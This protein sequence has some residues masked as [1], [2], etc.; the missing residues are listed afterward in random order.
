M[1]KIPCE[2]SKKSPHLLPAGFSGVPARS[3]WK[4]KRSRKRILAKRNKYAKL[5]AVY[6]ADSF[7]WRKGSYNTA[8]CGDDRCG[9]RHRADGDRLRRSSRFDAGAAAFVWCGYSVRPIDV[10]LYCA[11]GF[12]CVEFRRKT[13]FRFIALPIAIF[14]LSGIVMINL[15]KSLDL[16]LIGAAFGAFLLA[17][18]L[19]YLLFAG[20]ASL[21]PTRGVVLACSAV[22]GVFSG[23]FSIGGPMMALCLLPCAEDHEQYVGNMQTLFVV[24]NCINIAARVANGLYTVELI[25]I[26]LVGIVFILLGRAIGTRLV[27]QLSAEVIKRAVYRFVGISGAMTLI[28]NIL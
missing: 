18:S 9:G 21:R 20:R 14:S 24:T 8:Y 6:T 16:W 25:P 7:V 12:A 4:T 17:L 5:S 1:N 15:I 27:R 19:Y 28:E 11:D 2:Y 10:H 22:S 26:S 23:L 13:N 3:F